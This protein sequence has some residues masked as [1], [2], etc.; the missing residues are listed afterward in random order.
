VCALGCVFGS[1]LVVCIVIIA[2]NLFTGLPGIIVLI[3]LIGLFMPSAH[4]D[5]GVYVHV[6]LVRSLK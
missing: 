5:L 2:F 3:V 1:V 4:R 6:C